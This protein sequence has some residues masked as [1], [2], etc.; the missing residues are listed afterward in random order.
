MKNVRN[1]LDDFIDGWVSL[2]EMHGERLLYH[3]WS[4]K[5]EKPTLLS[6]SVDGD[7]T[8][9]VAS[10]L[11]SMRDVDRTC[12]LYEAFKGAGNGSRKN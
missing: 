11:T 12:E 10:V 5:E 3:S 4:P 6:T 8:F 1:E 7:V 2:A 9:A